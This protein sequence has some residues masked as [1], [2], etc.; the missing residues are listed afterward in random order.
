VKPRSH[1]SRSCPYGGG[2][3]VCRFAVARVHEKA[4]PD[5]G[6]YLVG[7]TFQS[8]ATKSAAV[9]AGTIQWQRHP[10]SANGSPDG[11]AQVDTRTHT[12]SRLLARWV[13]AL[14]YTAPNRF[15]AEGAL[16][17]GTARGDFAVYAPQRIKDPLLS[18]LSHC[19]CSCQGAPRGQRL[20]P[21]IGVEK[22]KA[23]KGVKARGAT[24]GR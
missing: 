1:P 22:Q 14:C 2:L 10:P 17:V 15:G 6:D 9:V 24:T 7:D 8:K 21:A 18:A 16:F 13:T 19:P 5:E 23:A 3:E 4:F 12:V 20:R 11:C